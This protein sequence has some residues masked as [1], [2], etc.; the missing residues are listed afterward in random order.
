MGI[1]FPSGNPP[2]VKFACGFPLWTII[3]WVEILPWVK[4]FFED[5]LRLQFLFM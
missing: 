2:H 4:V 3:F 5:F 1:I